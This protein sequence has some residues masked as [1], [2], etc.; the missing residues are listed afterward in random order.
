M[1]KNMRDPS[2]IPPLLFKSIV[3]MK[4]TIFFVLISAY[5]L[6]ARVYGQGNITLNLQQTSIERVL[7]TIEKG[8]NFRFLYN[9][10]LKSLKKKVDISVENAPL[11]EALEKLFRD[12]DLTFKLLANNLVVVLLNTT[13]KQDIRITGKVTDSTGAPL[14][15]VSIVVKGSTTGTNTDNDGNY[16]LTVPDNAVLVISYIGYIDKE[17]SVA[18]QSVINVTLAASTA[19]LDEVVVVGYG[20]QRKKDVTGA[21]SVVSAADIANRPIVNAAEALQGKAAGVQVVSNSGKPGAGL[22]IRIRGSSS[23]SAGNDPLYVVDG[24]PMTDITALN[25]G[26]IESMTILKDA[27]SASIYGTRAANGVVVITTKKGVAGKPRIEFGYYYGSTSTTKKLDVLNASQYQAYM[28]ETFGAGTIT[29]SMVQANNINWPDEVFRTGSQANYQVSVSGGNDKTQHFVSL[30]YNDQVGMIRPSTFNRLSGRVN[31]TS[32]VNNWLTLTSSTLVSRAKQYGVTDNASVARGGVVLSALATPPTVGKYKADGS[33]AQNPLTGWENPLGAI[34]GQKN[35]NTTDRIVSNLGAELRLYKGLTFQSRFGI[36]YQNYLSN[37][38]LDPFLTQ[39]GR[40][41]KGR[42][43]E[44]KSTQLVWLTEQTLNYNV[45]LGKSRI[46]ALAGWTAQESRWDQTVISGTLIDPAYRNKSFNEIY[47]RAGTKNPS[48]KSIDEWALTSWLGRIS[49]DFDGKYLL[50]ANIRSDRSSKFAPENRTATFPSFSAGWRISEEEF[51]KNIEFFD[52]LKLRAGWGQNGN[53]EG[54]GSYQY[55]SLSNINASDGSTT[56]ASIAPSDLRWETST[57]TNVGLDASF[58]NRRINFSADFYVKKT[59]DVLVNIPLPS[60][61]GFTSVLVNMGSMRNIGQEFVINSRNVVNKNFQWSTDLNISFNRNKV[62]SIGNGIS[63]MNGYGNI[64]ERGNS[65]AL[66]QGYGLGTFYGYVA[67]GV[68]PATGKQLYM[69]KDGKAVPYTEIR[70][71]DRQI[72]GSAQ[73]DFVYGMTNNLSYKNFDLTIF[74]QGSQ[75]ND[76]LNGVR[77]ETE[78]MKDSRNQSTDVLNR[79]KAPGDNSSIPGVSPASNDNTQI[80]TRFIENGSYLRFKTITLAYRF[81]PAILNK[82]GLG[83]AS[84]YV[85]AQN[86]ITITKYK[87]FDPEVNTYGTATDTD[88]RNISLGVDYGA[89]PQAKVL[90]FGVNVSLK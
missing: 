74:L 14:A 33:I 28:N 20:S 2:R 52:E 18:G 12:T 32:K 82:I 58:F 8:G 90:L 45:V 79:W 63:F 73:P 67:A 72:I 37:N 24:I 40:N 7:G 61:A 42:I 51:F 57:Q 49:Y 62:L 88:N 46:S 75:G 80:S 23:I 4:L 68:D 44:T 5:H 6:Q 35:N 60:Q 81:N 76:I 10:D 56:P 89:Y 50:Q 71:S 66:V 34:E 55:L 65:I 11:S 48:V 38:F 83:T 30:N 22:S 86:L 84:V 54:I 29:D 13:E 36:D 15:G 47:M 3:I 69:S 53:Q 39:D 70:P 9:Y 43:S 41:N 85:S 25:P 17:V 31:L 78:G 1:K 87:G 26:D 19:K 59:D 77:I 27:A 64:Y 16:S 21:V